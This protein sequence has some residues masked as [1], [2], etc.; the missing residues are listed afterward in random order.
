MN[1][2]IQ[3]AEAYIKQLVKELE[4]V[5]DKKERKRIEQELNTLTSRIGRHVKRAK[6]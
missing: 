5:K 2:Q 6:R 1:Q 3:D 4:T